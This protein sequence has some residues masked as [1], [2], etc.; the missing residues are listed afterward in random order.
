MQE[1]LAAI[2]FEN[3]Q[4]MQKTGDFAYEGSLTVDT[5]LYG[6]KDGRLDS[7]SLVRLIV[8]VEQGIQDRL[9]LTVSLA[10][11]K[12]LSQTRTPFRSVST[13]V[14]HAITVIGVEEK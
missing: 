13:L 12:A 2:I 3:L 7:L 5:P 11:P 14:N 1:Q 9:N 10:D 4:E 6:G 8:A